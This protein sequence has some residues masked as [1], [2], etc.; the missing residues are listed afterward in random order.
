[1][2]RRAGRR[3]LRL[4]SRRYL[5]R[6]R[7][8]IALGLLIGI[9]AVASSVSG[10][11]MPKVQNMVS[12][13]PTREVCESILSLASEYG[14][15]TRILRGDSDSAETV[16]DWQERRHESEVSGLVSPLRTLDPKAQV[17]TCLYSGTFVTPSGPPDEKGN[18]P[19][20]HDVLR[21]LVLPDGAVVLD[22]AGYQGRMAPELPKELTST[23]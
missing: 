6:H 3:V 11:S 12:N 1:M 23:G 14:T 5:S 10:A 4:R 20:P 8:A 16:A 17:F 7:G 15:I 13:E 2:E 21:L 9:A 19:P 18:P 22:S